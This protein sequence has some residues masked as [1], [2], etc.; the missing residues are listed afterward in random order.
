[1]LG[2]RKLILGV[3][4]LDY[5]KG[6]PERLE[7]FA[8]LLER[9]PRVAQ[10]GLVRPGLGADARPRSPSTPSCA[11]ASRRWS[12]GS[13]ARTARRT[14]C[15]CAT[16][17]APTTRTR[18]RMLYRQAA[19]GLVTPLRDGMNLV[20]KE[21][22]ASQDPADPGVLVLSRFCGAAE[23]MTLALLTNPY[24]V[25]GVATDLDA[26]LRMS[27]DDRLA[28]PRGAPHHGLAG[29]RRAR[30]RR[31]SSTSCGRDAKGPRTR[32]LRPGER[33]RVSRRCRRRR[34]TCR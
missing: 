29:H 33:A 4:R 31:R 8:R 6:I 25:D 14:G 19:V 5:S 30:G 34:R 18:S 16:S 20:A 21:F 13:T 12:A 11:R 10:P 1:M 32:A 23:R 22:V 24:H 26:A 15:R 7:A 28:A 2:G 27:P 3:D 9:Y 17:I